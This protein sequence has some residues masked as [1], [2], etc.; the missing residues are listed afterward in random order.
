MKTYIID[1]DRISIYLSTMEVQ[2]AGYTGE[3]IPF[4]SAEEALSALLHDIDN[5]PEII[6]LDLNMPVMDGWEFLE[7]LAP[8][9]EKLLG[10]CW[11]Y[12][13]TSS[14]VLSDTSK[15]EEYDLVCGLI[16][17]PLDVTDVQ[18]ILSQLKERA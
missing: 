5:V 6:F 8:Y 4:L 16:H 3:V 18:V 13:L 12:I 11:I 2:T 7:A 17:K 14:L 10:K 15:S 1:D 9:K